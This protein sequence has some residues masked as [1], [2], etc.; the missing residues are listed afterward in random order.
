MSRPPEAITASLKL[1]KPAATLLT[2]QKANTEESE[3][4][5]RIETLWY[6]R[7]IRQQTENTN[8]DL[9]FSHGEIP[10]GRSG[11]ERLAWG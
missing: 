7:E 2:L 1:S 5:M 9:R 11:S 6:C 8:I 4:E 10:K 3:A